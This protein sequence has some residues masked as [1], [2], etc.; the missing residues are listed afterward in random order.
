MPLQQNLGREA[1]KVML[2][3]EAVARRKK[4]ASM[5]KLCCT[6]RGPRTLGPTWPA[7]TR[8]EEGAHQRSKEVSDGIWHSGRSSGARATKPREKSTV[9]PWQNLERKESKNGWL[10][11]Q[12]TGGEGWQRRCGR[13]EGNGEGA[14]SC[15]LPY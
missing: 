3:E 6:G 1:K 5:G 2:T 8:T 4:T 12:L 7:M 14:C 9:S 11:L 10:E 13:K 15:A